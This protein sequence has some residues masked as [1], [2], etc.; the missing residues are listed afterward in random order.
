MNK[1]FADY[2]LLLLVPERGQRPGLFLRSAMAT[3]KML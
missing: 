3:E 1:V 2:L